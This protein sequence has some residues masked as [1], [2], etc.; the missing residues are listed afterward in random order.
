MLWYQVVQV[1]G[2]L[3][4]LSAFVAA[5]LGKLDHAGYRYLI[6]NA[7]GSAVL[8]A[9]AILSLEWGFILLEG[10]WAIVSLYSIVVRRR[11]VT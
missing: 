4:I 2:S 8:T 3:L 6:L 1:V 7:V 5:Q 10:V 9:T 11:A